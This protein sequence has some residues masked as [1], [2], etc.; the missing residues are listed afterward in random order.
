[1]KKLLKS[2]CE[3]EEKAQTCVYLADW[4]VNMAGLKDILEARKYYETAFNVDPGGVFSDYAASRMVEYS[5]PLMYPMERVEWML[6]T[7]KWDNYGWWQADVEDI[8]ERK[9]L[10]GDGTETFPSG[11]LTLAFDGEEPAIW[12]KS[13]DFDGDGEL[14]LGVNANF[15]DAKRRSIYILERDLD[16]FIQT[17]ADE[18]EL[19]GVVTVEEVFAGR[20]SVIYGAETLEGGVI[21]RLRRILSWVDGEYRIIGDIPIAGTDVATGETLWSGEL[22]LKPDEEKPRAY[23]E[24]VDYTGMERRVLEV[25]GVYEYDRGTKAFSLSSD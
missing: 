20:P 16:R 25:R 14:E 11:D 10:H 23:V 12:F 7:V 19:V 5:H 1:V 2:D 22:R 17:Y 21:T 9:I 4:Y 24:V 3:A 8:L 13:G 18:H 6:K 15:R